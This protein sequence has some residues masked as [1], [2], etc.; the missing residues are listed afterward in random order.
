MSQKIKNLEEKRN[1]LMVD[2]HKLLHADEVTIDA[3]AS[4]KAMF[5]EVDQIEND[6]L[7]LRRLA[8]FDASQAAEFNRSPRP[9]VNDGSVAVASTPEQRKA[10][11]NAAFKQYA[12]Y[13]LGSMN[14]EQRALLT[15][16]DVTGGAL[17]PQEWGGALYDALKFYGPIATRVTQKITNNDGRPMKLSFSNDTANGLTLLA[18]EGTSSPAETD[19][20]FVSV[21]SN[22]DT[23]TG[24]LVKVSFQELE[25]SAFDL[26]SWIR[27]KFA[28]RYARGVE[29]A[30]TLGT[31]SAGTALP[32]QATGGIISVASLGFTTATIA[33]G[34]GWT[35]LTSTY[36]KLDPA[37]ADNPDAAWVMNSSTRNYL[38]GLKDGFG[39]PYFTP[40]PNSG[41][42]FNKLLGHDI[43][44]NQSMV[45]PSANV[46]GA[47]AIPILFGDLKSSYMLRTDGAPSILRLNERY[48]ELLEVG[49]FL[50]TR[51]G[52]VSLDAG[53]HPLAKLVIAAS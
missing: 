44:L 19:P 21:L 25:D 32:S 53:T 26:D 11:F 46:F 20:A 10:N 3:R 8:S 40:D 6:L 17:I 27:E 37:Y 36:A 2:A 18:T 35:D 1:Q 14:A 42:P 45:G 34:I 51:V 43:V 31:D 23:V 47:N 9:V 52:G 48:A 50:Y 15:T 4:A 13:G 28:I 7:D 22:V 12:R 33:G 30:I 38:L 29:K 41:T 5:A 16:S 24:G 49:F 39:R